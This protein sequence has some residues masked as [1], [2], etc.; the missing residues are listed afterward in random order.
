MPETKG[1]TCHH[2]RSVLH[3]RGVIMCD[4]HALVDRLAEALLTSQPSYC[5]V[6]CAANFAK[7]CNCGANQLRQARVALLAEYARLKEES[8]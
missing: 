2:C 4:R 6:Y 8:E 3:S 5:D 7:A 1:K